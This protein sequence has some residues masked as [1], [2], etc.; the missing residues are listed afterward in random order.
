V[1]CFEGSFY[2]PFSPLIS[3]SHSFL[4]LPHQPKD[5]CESGLAY[6][7]EIPMV[8]LLPSVPAQSFLCLL[9]AALK[10]KGP[11]PGFRFGLWLVLLF[12]HFPGGAWVRLVPFFAS[13]VLRMREGRAR[14]PPPKTFFPVPAPRALPSAW[15]GEEPREGILA[16]PI[17]FNLF[18]QVF[19]FFPP[20]S[21]TFRAHP[22]P[23]SRSLKIYLEL[24]HLLTLP[25]WKSS[26]FPPLPRFFFFVI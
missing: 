22:V 1:G 4:F 12:N 24:P 16:G 13:S 17:L 9:T 7:P 5:E 14:C 10:E 2:W 20:L 25:S 26:A 11:L 19:P 6:Y 15:L 18:N 3:G 8:L 23:F 21:G